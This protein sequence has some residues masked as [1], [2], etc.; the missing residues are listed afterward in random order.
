[1]GSLMCNSSWLA[2]RN[3]YFQWHMM[4]GFCC[5]AWCV[6]NWSSTRSSTSACRFVHDNRFVYDNRCVT[7]TSTSITI[8]CNW[9]TYSSYTRNLSLLSTAAVAAMVT[10]MAVM[11]VVTIMATVMTMM[12]MMATM[13]TVVATMAATFFVSYLG[14]T[15]SRIIIIIVSLVLF[16]TC[17]F[18]GFVVGSF[19][20]FLCI[21]TSIIGCLFLF[22]CYFAGFGIFCFFLLNG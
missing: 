8:N 7:T 19:F 12:T 15:T 21:V 13:M 11:T 10:V 20:F 22:W 5:T 9:N 14:I 4:D 16:P 2:Y 18:L 6:V 1:M 3:L 17:S